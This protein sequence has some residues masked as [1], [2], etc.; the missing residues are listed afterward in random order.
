[1]GERAFASS[2]EGVRGK[3]RIFCPVGSVRYLRLGHELVDVVIVTVVYAVNFTLPIVPA[4][5]TY[6]HARV[7]SGTIT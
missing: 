4:R 3:G 7:E 5:R 2:C 1:V 6:A